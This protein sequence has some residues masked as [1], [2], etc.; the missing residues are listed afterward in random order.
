MGQLTKETPE[1]LQKNKI[2]HPYTY[3]YVK[4]FFEQRGCILLSKNYIN[5][6]TH[7]EYQCNCG[8]VNKIIFDSFRRGHGCNK[9]AIRKNAEKQRFNIND[10]KK[11]IEETGCKLLS[12]EYVGSSKQLEI[13]CK[14]GKVFYKRYNDF[15][16][17]KLYMC[18]D[19]GLRNRSGKNHY[20]WIED[21]EQ[22]EK[23]M[24]FRQRCYCLL[25]TSLK[26]VGKCKIDRTIKMLGYSFKDLQQYIFKHP[27][28][29]EVK[30]DKWHI[31]H[32]FPVQAF[33]D[34]GIY[35]IKLI[36]SLDNLQPMRAFQNI[37]K[38]DNYNNEDFEEWLKSKGF[39]LQ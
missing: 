13:Q 20:E 15:V 31:D 9:C 26:R 17:N 37:S 27:K 2:G 32:I 35:D 39:K 25:K 29:D 16:N 18:P 10:V 12:T 34:H 22:H 6:R 21:R 4:Q 30:G 24:C 28:W 33:L 14:C 36:N 38:G 5:A 3:E 1:K 7:L 19:C 11:V 8:S 23:D